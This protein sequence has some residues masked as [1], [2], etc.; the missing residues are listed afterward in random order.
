MNRIWDLSI[1]LTI[2]STF[3]LFSATTNASEICYSQAVTFSEYAPST[4]TTLF[5]CP[6]VGDKSLPQLAA[7]GWAVVSISS[8]TVSGTNVSDQLVLRSPEPIFR[9]G[10]EF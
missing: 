10:F 5:N 1:R 7:L 6:T 4:N 9:S 2:L 8:V 3:L